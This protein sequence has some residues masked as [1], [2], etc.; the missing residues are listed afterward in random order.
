MNLYALAFEHAQRSKQDGRASEQAVSS[1]RDQL[2]DYSYTRLRICTLIQL[3]CKAQGLRSGTL[4]C[5]SASECGAFFAYG[6]IRISVQSSSLFYKHIC[7]PQPETTHPL[8]EL[9]E[10]AFHLGVRLRP[11][12]MN[13]VLVDGSNSE[14]WRRDAQWGIKRSRVQSQTTS[15]LDQLLAFF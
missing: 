9:G 3:V 2:T 5:F 15:G 7:F 11:E 4:A 8:R 6:S 1:F 14:Y 13:V 10:F 12:R